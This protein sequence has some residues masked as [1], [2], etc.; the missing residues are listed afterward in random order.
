MYKITMFPGDGVGVEVA[1]QAVK[2]IQKIAKQFHLVFE[3][4]KAP[5]GGASI[6]KFGVPITPEAL[7]L[8]KNADAVFLGAVGGPKWDNVETAKRPEKALLAL[9]KTLEVFANLR[10]VHM[11]PALVSKSP[12]KEEIVSGLDFLILREL[13][14]G[15]YFGSPRGIKNLPG[16]G[17]EGINTEVYTTPEVERIARKAFEFARKRRK[18]V[19][20][21]DKANVLESSQLWRKVVMAVHK[22]FPDVELDHRYVDDCAM[23]L[24]RS[25]K[26]F[27][28]IVTTNLFGDILSDESA[29]LTG[30][31]GMLPS[32]SI[33]AHHGLY[34]PV[35]GSAPDIAG[36]DLANPLAS[37][38]SVAMMM[39]FSFGLHEM[40]RSIEKAVEKVLQDGYR[41]QDI[42]QEETEK[43]SCSRMGDLV[44]ERIK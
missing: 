18:K 28:V 33:G 17:E 20:S 7:T 5:L 23:Q 40:A 14:G 2:I 42:Y 8:A 10:P 37:I 44:A 39:E 34:E 38:L 9:R 25:P 43:V 31:I 12:L 29:M 11:F 4:E 32:A 22:E 21:V 36:K 19:T 13:I 27:D 35:H 6:D 16:G 30:S 41:T 1:E 26:Q 24:I 3:I 15:I